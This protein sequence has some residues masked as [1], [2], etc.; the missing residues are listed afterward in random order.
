MHARSSTFF[1]SFLTCLLRSLLLPLPRGFLLAAAGGES[2]LAGE[3]EGALGGE[4]KS[5]STD[6]LESLRVLTPVV[7]SP[8]TPGSGA[9]ILRR[10]WRRGRRLAPEPPSST[11]SF[12]RV[13]L[14]MNSTIC[15]RG[16]S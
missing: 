7:V 5:Q 3:G 8:R 12:I 14:G 16:G 9:G 15:M 1:L 13:T 2:I 10:C 6:D 4:S 11:F